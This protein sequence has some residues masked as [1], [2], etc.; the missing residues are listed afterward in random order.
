[1]GFILIKPC[2]IIWQQV[3]D[4]NGLRTNR[5]RNL[6]IAR[7][8]RQINGV[9][10]I[11]LDVIH[12]LINE[13][14][15]TCICPIKVIKCTYLSLCFTHHAFSM[16]LTPCIFHVE[17]H[18]SL[19][20]VQYALSLLKYSSFPRITEDINILGFLIYSQSNF[21]FLFL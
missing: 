4:V 6:W 21:L 16:H 15:Y 20:T 18:S 7:L 1:M 3:A 12:C 10:H 8:R 17:C 11:L 5:L 14:R 2:C 19:Q 13:R 9:Q